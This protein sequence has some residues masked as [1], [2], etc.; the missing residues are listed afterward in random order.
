MKVEVTNRLPK[1]KR[2]KVWVRIYTGDTVREQYANI[3]DVDSNG[4]WLADFPILIPD[5]GNYT[6][7]VE[8]EY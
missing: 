2:I 1:R 3:M 5:L 7:K 4:K 8:L 6:Y